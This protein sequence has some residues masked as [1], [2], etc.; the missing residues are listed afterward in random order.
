MVTVVELGLAPGKSMAAI[1]DVQALHINNRGLFGD[2]HCMWVEAATHINTLYRKGEV[3]APGQFLSQREDPIL[4]QVMPAF[5]PDGIGLQTRGGDGSSLLVPRTQDIAKNRIPVS[6]WSW[7]GEGVDQGDEAAEWGE[8]VIGRPVRLVAISSEKP[9]WVEG[10]SK[11]GR[12]GFSDGYPLTIASTDS[13]DAIN[14]ELVAAGHDPITMRRARANILLSGL[15]LPG[16]LEP[17]SGVFPEDYIET[18]RISSNGLMAVLRRIK[19][20]GRCPIPDTDQITGERKGS[21]VR[22]ALG[23]LARNGRHLDTE[24]YSTKP[25]LFWTQNFVI[26]LPEDMPPD[27]TIDIAKDAKV[28]ITYSPEANWTRTRAA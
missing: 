28:E 13:L 12:V 26:E 24:R 21:P 5:Q 1:E 15:V 27:A 11:L 20:C 10:D 25:E 2:R 17:H 7:H 4:T 18:I 6:V 16:G 8:S 19:A 23:Q 14:E 22:Q 3:A 9:R